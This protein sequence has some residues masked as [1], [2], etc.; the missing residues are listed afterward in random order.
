MVTQPLHAWLGGNRDAAQR[1]SHA[2]AAHQVAATACNDDNPAN[3]G[4]WRNFQTGAAAPCPDAMVFL[5]PRTLRPHGVEE[6]SDFV[7]AVTCE[8]IALAKLT[9]EAMARAQRPGAIVAVCDITGVCGRKGHADVSAAAGALIGATKCLAKELGRQNIS[10]NA[11]CHGIVPDLGVANSLSKPER[12]FFDMMGL[13]RPGTIEHVVE[14]IAHLIR[15]RH[16][17]T[18]QVLHVDDGLV[19]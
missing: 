3:A 17:M 14:N 16:F 5:A 12:Q 1:V 6:V 2:L 13:A 18:G 15:N 7:T 10:V 4:R 9:V 11:I 8:F 19:M